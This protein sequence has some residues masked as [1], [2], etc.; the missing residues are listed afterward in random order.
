MR[1]TEI[2]ERGLREVEGL[3]IDPDI[4][5]GGMPRDRDT[6]VEGVVLGVV[7]HVEYHEMHVLRGVERDEDG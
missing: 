6:V 7:P 2:G 3:S 5:R 4:Y 1:V